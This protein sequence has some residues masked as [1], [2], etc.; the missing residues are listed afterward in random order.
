V[1]IRKTVRI[2]CPV[3]EVWAFIADLRNDPRWC[4]KVAAVEQVAGEGPGPQARY[5]VIHRP[6]R[7]KRPKLL[8]VSVE[9]HEPPRRM[10][11]R[12]EDDDAVFDVTY[13]LEQIGEGTGLTQMDQIEWK[14]P[15][16]ARPIGGLMVS[17]DLGRQ[18]AT[19]KRLLEAS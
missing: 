6:V 7:L 15:M 17:R 16:P 10:R 8:A 18:F 13:E 4:D 19:L 12:E 3:D 5:R 2:E 11:L 1:K 9:E 14:I